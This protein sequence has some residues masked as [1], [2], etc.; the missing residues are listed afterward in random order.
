MVGERGMGMRASVHMLSFEHDQDPVAVEEMVAQ[1]KKNIEP[2]P[3]LVSPDYEVLHGAV[4]A[5][6]AK[7]VGWTSVPIRVIDIHDIQPLT[8]LLPSEAVAIGR[9]LW[10]VYREEIAATALVQAKANLKKANENRAK[11]I[12]PKGRQRGTQKNSTRNR[13]AKA[14]GM[15]GSTWERARWVVRMAS[16]E[17]LTEIGKEQAKLMLKEMDSVSI[18]HAF[19]GIEHLLPTK[20]VA[21]DRG[22][23]SLSRSPQ[24][25]IREGMGRLIGLIS[26]FDSYSM[27][28]ARLSSEEVDEWYLELGRAAK[29][30]RRLR[31]ELKRERLRKEVTTREES[32]R[33]N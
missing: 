29:T 16:S 15:S 7:V 17:M 22:R 27:L 24:R 13:V 25:A 8:D 12:K 23:R 28:D 18:N 10:P 33:V 30:I 19:T 32:N 31:K 4:T 21:K 20:G 6:A 5:V 9:L 14:F 11:G 1:L 2:R 26:G 3:V